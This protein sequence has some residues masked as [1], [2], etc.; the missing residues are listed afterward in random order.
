MEYGNIHINGN[1]VHHFHY[2]DGK[3]QLE[4]YDYLGRIIV[5]YEMSKEQWTEISKLSYADCWEELGSLFGD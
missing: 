3:E 1:K 5:T 2:N 4:A